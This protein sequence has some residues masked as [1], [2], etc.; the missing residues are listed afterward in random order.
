MKKESVGFLQIIVAGIIAGFI[1]ILVRFG[2][3]LGPYNLSFFRVFLAAIFLGLF[4]LVFRKKI[5]PLKYEKKKML[6]FGA[7]HGFILLG[8]FI[9]IQ[10][11]TIA[12]A[13]FLMYL[14]PIWMILLSF[15]ILKEKI[16]SKA[17][18][19][20]FISFIGLVILFSPK[21]FFIEGNLFGYIG[22]ILSGFGAGLVY[23]ISKTF[24]KYDK[25]S[26]TFWQ[27]LIAIPFLIPLLFI[28]FPKFTSFDIGI[29]VSIGLIT[30]IV[31]VLLYKGLGK[32]K[33][34]SAGAV[35]ILEIL[36]PIILAFLFFKE[37]PSK[38]TFVGG[39]LIII[40]AYIATTGRK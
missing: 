22:G 4:F 20:L 26:L 1:P 33:A 21:D 31:F 40:G 28:D 35:I 27:N 3:N 8:Y 37:I 5:S 16:T 29:V 12:T 15:F 17:L 11:L 10:K 30:P 2:K 32:V 24:K 18:L 19:A 38:F 39:I 23:V 25:I 14:F 34:S 36:V 13:V 6:V 7:V 9:A